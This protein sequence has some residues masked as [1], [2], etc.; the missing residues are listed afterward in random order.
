MDTDYL[1]LLL[2]LVSPV[3]ILIAMR[4]YGVL[5]SILIMLLLAFAFTLYSLFYSKNDQ[6]IIVVTL[7]AFLAG[8]VSDLLLNFYSSYSNGIRSKMLQKYFRIVGTSTASIFAGLLTVWLVLP[9]FVLYRSFDINES[10]WLF[11]IGF[12]VGF[13]I[14]SFSESSLALRPLLPFYKS[15]S[16]WIE[17]RS[18][19]GISVCVAMLPIVVYLKLLS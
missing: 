16:G 9:S 6:K 13:I 15:T 8:A 11:P 2:A 18:W 1:D 12:A 7:I 4:F 14:G 10:L 3:I 5:G 17:N 19:D